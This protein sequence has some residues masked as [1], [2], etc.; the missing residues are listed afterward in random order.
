[1]ALTLFGQE[2]ILIQPSS[3]V[4]VYLLG[5]LM[6]GLGIYFL[7]TRRNEKSRYIFGIALVLWGLGTLFAGSSYQA[8]GYELKCRGLE[9]CLFTDPLELIYLWLTACS[10]D[11]MVVAT[12]FI[13]VAES[14][15]KSLIR[16]AIL[17]ALAYFV[18]L[19]I[20]VVAPIRFLVSYEGFMLFMGGNFILMFVLNI[21]HYHKNKDATNRNFIGI[22][23]LFLAVNLGYFIYLFGEFG[24]SLHQNQGIWFHA[25]DMLHVLLIAWAVAIFF[26]LGKPLED[27]SRKVGSN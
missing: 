7:V 14:K 26:L 10:I 20:G 21:L 16:Y 23:L 8:F 12:A 13:S 5:F 1:V 2:L 6:L 25:N 27:G 22:W 17:H 9:Y 18:F 11:L 15:R 19:F 24:E 4:I 3:T